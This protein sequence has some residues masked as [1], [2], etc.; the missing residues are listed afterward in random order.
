MFQLLPEIYISFPTQEMFPLRRN[1]YTKAPVSHSVTL[2][3]GTWQ[4]TTVHDGTQLT[5]L[6]WSPLT[7]PHICYL[8]AKY[9]FPVVNKV[10][11]S[12]KK[13]NTSSC[14]KIHSWLEHTRPYCSFHRLLITSL[15]SCPTFSVTS[16]CHSNLKLAILCELCTSVPS[17]WNECFMSTQNGMTHYRGSPGCPM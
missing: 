2:I 17:V 1:N 13:I 7:L 11:S 5:G 9:S 15:L 16:I 6:P 3:L 8:E 14:I 10:N 12:K 4:N